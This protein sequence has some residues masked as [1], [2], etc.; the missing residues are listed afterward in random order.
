M[1][2]YAPENQ[3]A[4]HFVQEGKGRRKGEVKRPQVMSLIFLQA[5][6]SVYIAGINQKHQQ[7]REML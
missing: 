3:N 4:S 6:A 5:I 2:V 7:P 1:I